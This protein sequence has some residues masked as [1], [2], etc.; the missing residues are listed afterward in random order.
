MWLV[1]GERGGGRESENG[2]GSGRGSGLPIGV[3]TAVMFISELQILPE[4][5][6]VHV[7]VYLGAI[8]KSRLPT[9]IGHTERGKGGSKQQ[10]V[11]QH[12]IHLHQIRSF[13]CHTQWKSH[14]T[15]TSHNL[16]TKNLVLFS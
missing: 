8:Q 1:C 9:N 14:Y 4:S 11:K 10:L 3:K 7:E 6:N 16:A 5:Y 12:T 15:H 2:R 13:P